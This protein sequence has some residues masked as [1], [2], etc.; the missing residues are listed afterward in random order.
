MTSHTQSPP[1]INRRQLA[2][3]FGIPAVVLL[4]TFYGLNPVLVRAGVPLIWSFSLALYGTVYGLL[5]AALVGYWREGHPLL[6][7]AFAQRMRLTQMTGR[8]WAWVAGAVVLALLGDGLLEPLSGWMVATLPLPVPDALPALF[9]PAVEFEL[10]PRAFFGVPLAGNAWLIPFYAVCVF[11]NIA[12]EELWWRGFLL[13]RM[14]VTFGRWAWLLNG[15]LW[16]IVF[17]AATWWLYPTLIPTG[18]LAPFVAWRFRNTWASIAVHG[19]GNALFIVLIAW[20]V[21]GG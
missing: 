9:D 2:L 7:S 13:P 12:G 19:T 15:L 4:L 16:V 14:E 18:L 3:T 21:Y 11:G 10:P 8:Q 6:W 20:G 1:P 17:H 5:I